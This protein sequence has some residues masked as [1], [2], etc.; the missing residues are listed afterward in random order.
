[1][2]TESINKQLIKEEIKMFS[3]YKKKLFNLTDE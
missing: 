1:M 2:S 3:K